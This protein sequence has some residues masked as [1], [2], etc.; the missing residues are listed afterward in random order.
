MNDKQFDALLEALAGVKKAV[1]VN[2]DVIDSHFLYLGDLINDLRDLYAIKNG[3]PTTDEIDA[4]IDK[5]HK[6]ANISKIG[7]E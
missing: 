3:F 6:E 7:D 4:E 5:L 2:T 1:Q